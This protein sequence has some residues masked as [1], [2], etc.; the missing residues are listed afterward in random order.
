[1]VLAESLTGWHL[2]LERYRRKQDEAGLAAALNHL[3][4]FQEFTRDLD[5]LRYTPEAQAT[6]ASLRQ[7]R[8]KRGRDDLRIA[9]ICIAHNVPLLTRN[10]RDFED[11]P[12][13]K[14]K[15]W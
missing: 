1:V 8:G 6:F 2:L 7:G 14:L 3:C 15:T 11:L 10:V 4:E 5:L 13:L 12:N 9:A